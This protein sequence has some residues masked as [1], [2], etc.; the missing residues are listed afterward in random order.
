MKTESALMDRR[1]TL[2]AEDRRLV[3][4]VAAGVCLTIAPQCCLAA[5]TEGGAAAAE[6]KQEIEADWMRQLARAREAHGGPPITPEA[7]AAGA[8]DGCELSGR[9]IVDSA[10]FDH[11]HARRRAGSH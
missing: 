9:P 5:D 2:R 1:K 6:W 4:M 10:T 7:D 3:A 11:S 8:C